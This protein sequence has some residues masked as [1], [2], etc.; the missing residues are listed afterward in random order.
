LTCGLT[1]GDLTALPVTSY[2]YSE[3][4]TAFSAM[5]QARHTGKIVL[6]PSG[7]ETVAAGPQAPAVSSEGTY[8]ITGGLGALGLETARYL[9]GKGARHLVLV[10]RRPPSAAARQA[11]QQ[12]R[13]A[14][15]EVRV[16]AADVSR[17]DDVA[18]LVTEIGTSMPPLTGIVHAAGILDDGF[19]L[20]LDE[21]R[22]RSVAA[23]KADA[24]WHLHRASRDIPLDFFVLYSSAAALLGSPGQGNYAAANAF[25]DALA[26]YRHSLGLP[27]LSIGWGPWSQI[28]L[29]ADPS[30]GGSLPAY[31]I[32]SLRPEDGI[33]ALD[34]LLFTPS[35]QATVLPLDRARLRDAA[36]SGML[37]GLL[38]GLLA[39]S[40]GT[41]GTRRQGSTEIRQK[42]LAVEPGRRRSA[43]LQQHCI[44]EAARVLK[45]DVSKIDAT[46]PLA[47]MGFDS[48]MSLELR[49]RLET[50]LGIELSATVAWRFPTI[51]KLVPFLADRMEVPLK[52]GPAG[53]G[54]AAAGGPPAAAESAEPTGAATETGT[55]DHA[56]PVGPAE[57]DLAQL[58]DSD[59]E[60]LLLAKMTR[61]DEGC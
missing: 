26:V 10:G 51:E 16:R 29:A 42:L 52:P 11:V 27:A 20:Q 32:A 49:K 53:S 17:F 5:A 33:A 23:P 1:A 3:A 22:F 47:S 28:G 14:Q 36:D 18:A 30:R 7:N 55:A 50:S 35:A 39:P 15:A 2:P 13:A 59:L 25:L 58:S 46:A 48:L 8:L 12:L 24:A 60:A 38:A 45:T 31:G 41:A 9:T 6:R 56:E 57:A 4:D 43:I 19:L 37:P 54:P 21:E 44:S 61:I 40:A 34:R